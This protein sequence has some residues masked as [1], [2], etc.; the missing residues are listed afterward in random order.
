M[1]QRGGG[2]TSSERICHG[3]S[4]LAGR[5]IGLEHLHLLRSDVLIS[6]DMQLRCLTR[7]NLFRS[8]LHDPLATVGA[9]VDNFALQCHPNQAETREK[10]KR[11]ETEIRQRMRI[12]IKSNQCCI[13]FQG[14]K[15]NNFC[16]EA[17]SI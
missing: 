17:R 11:T 3:E 9:N 14:G 8:E 6:P 5:P 7:T 16:P 15:F 12:N 4:A 2:V 13:A 10:C 1:R